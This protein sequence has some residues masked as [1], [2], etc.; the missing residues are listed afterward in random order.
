MKIACLKVALLLA[1]VLLVA[2]G[3]TADNVPLWLDYVAEIPL[4]LFLIGVPVMGG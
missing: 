4:W 2:T 1:A 3:Y